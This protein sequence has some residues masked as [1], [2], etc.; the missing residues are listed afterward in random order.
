MGHEWFMKDK[1]IL[2]LKE[3]ELLDRFE[4]KDELLGEDWSNVMPF[5]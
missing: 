4:D 3:K 1:D 5:Y 2:V